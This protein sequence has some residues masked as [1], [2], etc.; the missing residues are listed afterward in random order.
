M[1]KEKMSDKDRRRAESIRIEEN[2]TMKRE[3]IKIKYLKV[4]PTTHRHRF[5]KNKI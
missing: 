1:G 4:D 3:T 2:M 5:E